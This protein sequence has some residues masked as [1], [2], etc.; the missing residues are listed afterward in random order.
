MIEFFHIYS[1]NSV[2]LFV[3]SPKLSQEILNLE[4]TY[5]SRKLNVTI[6]QKKYLRIR[7][8]LHYISKGHKWGCLL[9]K[10]S[11]E[12]VGEKADSSDVAENFKRF[13][14]KST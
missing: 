2:L 5:L 6:L 1:L 7:R 12:K 9:H 13:L 14:L 11:R 3:F 8:C 10:V 4:L